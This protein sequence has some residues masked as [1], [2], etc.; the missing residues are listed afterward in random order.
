MFLQE[1][2]IKTDAQEEYNVIPT[3]LPEPPEA[4]KDEFPAPDFSG[5]MP[6][7]KWYF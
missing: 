5:N 6:Q 4:R 7:L 1:G 2:H 3:R